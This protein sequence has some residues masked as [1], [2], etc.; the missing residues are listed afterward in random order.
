M[1]TQRHVTLLSVGH[2]RRD[3]TRAANHITKSSK[4][5]R[6]D[7]SDDGSLLMMIRRN[8]S[9][10]CRQAKF[11]RWRKSRRICRRDSLYGTYTS[12]GTL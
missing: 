12:C 2:R 9:P 10:F 3:Y 4:R 6:H 1:S 8:E 5:Q 11:R 7:N